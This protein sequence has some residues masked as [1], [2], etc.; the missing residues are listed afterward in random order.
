MEKTR[1]KVVLE[2]ITVACSV[3]GSTL[4]ALNVVV[5]KFAY[6]VFIIG[7]L[8]GLRLMHSSNISRSVIF[9]SYYFLATD[10]IGVARW[11]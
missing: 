6:P 3:A 5:S 2:V 8:C 11:F 10:L 1:E 9:T 7:G 4:L